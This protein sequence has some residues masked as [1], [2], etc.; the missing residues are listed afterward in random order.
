MVCYFSPAEFSRTP[1][2]GGVR[3]LS[4]GQWRWALWR[5]LSGLAMKHPA[6][7]SLF[8]LFCPHIWKWRTWD[9]GVTCWRNLNPWVD[10]LQESHWTRNLH[11][12]IEW[13]RNQPLLCSVTEILGLFVTAARLFWL[14][15]LGIILIGKNG[16]GESLVKE[17]IPFGGNDISYTHKF[18]QKEINPSVSSKNAIVLLAY[19]QN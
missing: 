9:G 16:V 4:V 15:Q 13:T 3:W 7:S 1:H 19:F 17:V 14:I 5:A 18:M 6:W 2:L 11:I 10:C 8:S 12:G